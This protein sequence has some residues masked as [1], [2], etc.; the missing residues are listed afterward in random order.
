MRIIISLLFTIGVGFGQA[1]GIFSVQGE[2]LFGIE[3]QYESEDVDG[4]SITSTILGG[5]YVLDGDLE[6]FGSYYTAEVK[7]D[8][9]SSLDYDMTGFGYGGFY[10]MKA[11]ESFPV[12]VK[13]GGAFST[14]DALGDWL[15]NAGAKLTGESSAFGGGVY[16]NVYDKNGTSIMGFINIFSVKTEVT[17]DVAENANY[18]AYRETTKD[19]FSSLNFGVAVRNGDLFIAPSISRNDDDSSFNVTLGFLLPQ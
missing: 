15:D 16:K 9:D 12:N 5:S 4:G 19:E 14:I 11:D 17:L 7:N 18:Y 1:T 10:H 3:G 2:S 6:F 13:I 8:N